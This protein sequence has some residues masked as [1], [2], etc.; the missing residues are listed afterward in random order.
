MI[1]YIRNEMIIQFQQKHDE[2]YKSKDKLLKIIERIG[3]YV[4]KEGDKNG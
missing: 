2:Y 3:K 1:L 4:E